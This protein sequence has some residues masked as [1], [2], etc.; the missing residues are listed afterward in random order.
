LNNIMNK[1]NN[2]DLRVFLLDANG[3]PGVYKGPNGDV[4]TTAPYPDSHS[5]SSGTSDMSDY[6]ET[7]SLSSHSSSDIP[8]S[9]RLGM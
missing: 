2:R 8:D 6:I 7:L 4:I 5:T 9:L 1:V 3:R